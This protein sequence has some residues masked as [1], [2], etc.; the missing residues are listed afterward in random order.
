MAWGIPGKTCQQPSSVPKDWQTQLA[1]V[2]TTQPSGYRANDTISN[3]GSRV[4]LKFKFHQNTET[5][6]TKSGD[7]TCRNQFG[8]KTIMTQSSRLNPCSGTRLHKYSPHLPDGQRCMDTN[9][10]IS[11]MNFEGHFLQY[12]SHSLTLP[13]QFGLKLVVPLPLFSEY[14]NCLACVGVVFIIIIIIHFSLWS[15]FSRG[16]L[17]SSRL[18]SPPLIYLLP[19]LICTLISSLPLLIFLAFLPLVTN[20]LAHR[21]YNSLVP[22]LLKNSV[23]RGN[24]FQSTFYCTSMVNLSISCDYLPTTTATKVALKIL[25]FTLNTQ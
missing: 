1:A 3:T 11:K 24:C 23:W 13:K 15:T 2:H 21:D 19:I 22:L 25:P 5:Q 6:R 4:S 8:T 12:Y 17:I 20:I 14:W 16:C 7:P 10:L 9:C 18:C